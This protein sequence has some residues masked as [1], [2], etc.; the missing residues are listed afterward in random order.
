VV[1]FRAVF[2]SLANVRGASIGRGNCDFL[3]TVAANCGRHKEKRRAADS[4]ACAPLIQAVSF[5]AKL[6]D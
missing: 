1:R 5:K 4:P 2:L 3:V 6:L